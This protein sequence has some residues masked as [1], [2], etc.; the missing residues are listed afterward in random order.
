MNGY[1]L[2]KFLE[3]IG[4]ITIVFLVIPGFVAFATTLDFININTENQW[5][6]FWGS[7]FG[8]ILGSVATIAG[9]RLTLKEEQRKRR[10]EEVARNNEENERR[11]LDILP[12]MTSWFSIVKSEEEFDGTVSSITN[13]TVS[14]PVTNNYSR[15]RF[16]KEIVDKLKSPEKYYL[17]RY[18]IKNVGVGSAVKVDLII[19]NLKSIINGCLEKNGE[20]DLVILLLVEDLKD[21][22][23]NINIKY[24]DVVGVGKYEQNE[25]LLFKEKNNDI[26]LSKSEPMS[27]PMKM[28]CR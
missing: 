9:V 28:E 8:G 17:L 20:I 12:Y 5:I 11:R 4:G 6:G 1:W 15:E 26:V 3:I 13:F 21:K 18:R 19:D 7:Y 25:K 10:E 16:G 22:E 2:R 23:L 27:E 14:P 24:A